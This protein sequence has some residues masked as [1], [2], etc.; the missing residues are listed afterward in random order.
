MKDTVYITY[1]ICLH[2]TVH[3]AKS[4]FLSAVQY[5]YSYKVRFNINIQVIHDCIVRTSSTM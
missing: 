1:Q 2:C 3:A 4:G 5:N